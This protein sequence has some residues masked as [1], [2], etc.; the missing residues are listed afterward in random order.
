MPHQCV[1]CNQFY[2]DGS[3]EIIKGCSCGAKL[4]FFIKKEKMEKLRA[5]QEQFVALPEAEKKQ[6]EKD[7]FSVMGV[8]EEEQD[9][10]VIL[11]IES[12]RVVK[13]GKFELDLVNLFNKE[14]PIIFKLGEGKY[15][16][17]L[18]ETFRRRR[19]L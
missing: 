3:N 14:N 17:D 10:P 4:F 19:T 6:I 15:M 9:E 11:D 1:R 5:V 8:E 7:V 12:I 13:P 2:E 18:P 16:I